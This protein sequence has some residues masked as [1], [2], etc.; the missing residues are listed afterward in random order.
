[1][2]RRSRHVSTTTDIEVL[3][4]KRAFGITYFV[5]FRYDGKVA[6]EAAP[7]SGQQLVGEYYDEFVLTDDGWRFAS[8]RAR[9]AFLRPAVAPRRSRPPRW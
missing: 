1:M 8:R 3:T 4:S 9:N 5:L 7:M 2:Q 6:K